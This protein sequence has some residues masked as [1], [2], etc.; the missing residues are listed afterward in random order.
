MFPQ[1]YFITVSEDNKKKIDLMMK[2]LDFNIFNKITQDTEQ[3]IYIYYLLTLQ[4]E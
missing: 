1:S 4:D 2:N 3:Q